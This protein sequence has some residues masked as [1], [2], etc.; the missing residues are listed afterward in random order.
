[1][2]TLIMNY[3]TYSKEITLEDTIT[4][5]HLLRLLQNIFQTQQEILGITDPF[6]KFYDLSY[7][8][9]HIKTLNN[10]K[11]NIVTAKDA[12]DK[13]SFGSHRSNKR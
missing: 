10:H 6:G 1:M 3:R 7:A 11:F 13:V 2:N 8:A 9:Q 5:A 12:I 4:P